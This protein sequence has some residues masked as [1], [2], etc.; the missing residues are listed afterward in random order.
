MVNA[1]FNWQPTVLPHQ[2]SVDIDF[3]W[4]GTEA[5]RI[6]TVLHRLL[7]RVGLI[8]I[9]SVDKQVEQDLLNRVP[10]LLKAMGSVGKALET[11]EEIVRTALMQALESE[12]GRWIL[13]GQHQDAKCE[14]ALTGVVDGRLVN[15]VIDRTF[16][17]NEGVRWIIDYK[18][19]YRSD[20]DLEAF[21]EEEVERYTPQLNLYR[22]LFEGLGETRIETALYL[23]RHDILRC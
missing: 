8:G 16:V 13:S 12:T 19:G 20:G 18:S 5:R 17:D 14:L 10:Q 6:G 2:R 21:I 22:K 11:S 23:P 4:A 7:E 1:A 9:E 15:A 3:N